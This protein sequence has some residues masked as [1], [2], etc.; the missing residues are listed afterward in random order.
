VN[1]HRI[2]E[3]NHEALRHELSRL[4]AEKH[5]TYDA[6]ADLTDLS[7]TVLINL[8][9]GKTRG[10]LDT[11]HKVAH[12]LGVPLSTLVEQLCHDHRPASSP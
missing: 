2:P 3:P 9:T 4:R 5:L 6:L 11:W 12:A 10:S 1:R 7:R 8:E